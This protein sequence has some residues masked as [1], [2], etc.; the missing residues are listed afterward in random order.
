VTFGFCKA[1]CQATS[2]TQY[3]PWGVTRHL[4]GEAD[5]A[6][7]HAAGSDFIGH[8]GHWHCRQLTSAMVIKKMPAI[9]KLGSPSASPDVNRAMP[10][11]SNKPAGWRAL[12]SDNIFCLTASGCTVWVPTLHRLSSAAILARVCWLWPTPGSFAL[13]PDNVCCVPLALPESC[14]TVHAVPTDSA[15]R[16]V[17][18]RSTGPASTWSQQ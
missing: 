12:H 14:F 3:R 10:I 5:M 18:L 13:V 16:C 4:N 2:A 8:L 7:L 15:M 11:T 9:E 1:T 6:L 17:Y